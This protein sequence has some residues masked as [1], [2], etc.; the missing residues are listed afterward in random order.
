MAGRFD[1]VLVES[2]DGLK[3][4]C[5]VRLAGA[6]VERDRGRDAEHVWKALRIVLYCLT[7][8]VSRWRRCSIVRRQNTNT[9][10]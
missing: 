3:H 6:N 9:N 8:R 10:R 7:S 4:C 5:A 2:C 1:N